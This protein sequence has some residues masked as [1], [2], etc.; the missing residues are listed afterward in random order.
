MKKVLLIAVGIC[1]SVFTFAQD[2][3][4]KINQAQ[5]AMKAK[6]YAKAYT[7]YDEAMSNLGDVQVDASVNFNIG[8]AACKSGNVEG[9]EKYMAKAIEAKV[10][11]SDC[12]VN[13]AEL[14]TDKKDFVKAVE[15]YEK[16]IA[17]AAEGTDALA[18][19]AGSAAYNGKN[20]DKAVEMFNKCIQS[21]YKGET[22]YYY[23]SVILK[24]Q[25][26][27]DESKV[28]LEEG[29]SKFPGDAKMAP[30]LAK[31]YVGEG[32]ELY[33]KGAAIVSEAN[34]KVTAGKLKT[35]DPA[36]AAEVSKAKV[37]FEAAIAVL[38]KAKALDATNANVQKLLDACA[39]AMK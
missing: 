19:K 1:F 27:P 16:A 31:V 10:K 13:L 8:F 23:K 17:T 18:F 37:E 2:A 4:E 32:N 34:T 29:I 30:A 35:D 15:N 14:Y 24:A 20:Y 22:A 5:E 6:D 21:N 36:Y 9:A 28:A 12:Y 3:A 38:E 11:I 39:A 26:K 7:L 33:K 25:N